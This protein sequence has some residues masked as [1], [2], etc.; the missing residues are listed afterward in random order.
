MNL[1]ESFLTALDSLSANKLR[2]LLTMLGVI[3]GV[4]AVIGLLGIGNGFR[5]SVEDDINAIGTNLIF[6]F[7]NGD[8][9]DGYQALSIED[10]EALKDRS[11]VPDVVDAFPLKAAERVDT[12]G[13]GIGNNADGDDDGEGPRQALPS[14][15]ARWLLRH[16]LDDSTKKHRCYPF[17]LLQKSEL[18]MSPMRHCYLPRPKPVAH[19]ERNT[20]NRRRHHRPRSSRH[21]QSR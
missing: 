11:R 19:T 6:I 10:V 8:N 20:W 7:T 16:V 5:A 1:T 21:F 17:L 18:P 14:L 3:I 2:S 13:D 12:D 4:A 9:S 15:L